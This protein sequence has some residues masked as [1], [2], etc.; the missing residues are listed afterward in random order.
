VNYVFGNQARVVYTTKLDT[1]GF[2]LRGDAFN[3]WAGPVSVAIGGEARW[4]SITTNS[5]DPT[6]AS[7][8]FSRFNFSPLDGG[9]NVQEGFGEVAIPLLDQPF[10]KLDINGAARYSHYSSSGGIWS[11]KVGATD[12][13]FDNLLLRFSRSRDIRSASLTEMYTTVA[14]TFSTVTERGQPYPVT[15]Y[16]GGNPKL[17]PEIGS[18]L[19]LGAV[20]TPTAIPGLNLSVDYYKIEIKDAIV[21][22]TA[23]DIVNSCGLGN[24][25]ACAQI[26]RDGIVPTIVRSTYINLAQFKTHG[27]DMEASYTLPMSRISSLPGSL[28]FRALATYVPKV[29]FS[30]GVAVFQRAGDVGDDTTFGTPKWRGNASISYSNSDFS[31]DARVRYVGGGV[32]D[33]TRDIANNKINSRTYFD[34]GG[35]ATIGG[36]TWFASVNNLFDRKPPLTTYGSIFYDSIG[37]YINVGAKVHF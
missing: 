26:T 21:S 8:G 3:T 13:I 25:A 16:A 7:K 6:S 18:T 9:F 11:W 34:L 36:L 35:Q 15:R 20:L 17:R 19:T 10:S 29:E 37:R 2:S 5:L 27:L 1:T 32:Y 14:T 30:N 12:R 31:I 33:H 23:Q 4:E 22:L 24:G 28:R